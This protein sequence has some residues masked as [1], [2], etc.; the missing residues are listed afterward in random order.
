MGVAA[1]IIIFPYTTNVS[2]SRAE[3][4][5]IIMASGDLKGMKQH[6]FPC[7]LFKQGYKKRKEDLAV[8]N[9]MRRPK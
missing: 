5:I 7:Y 3:E 9:K 2:H 6:Q 1:R 8:F 4:I